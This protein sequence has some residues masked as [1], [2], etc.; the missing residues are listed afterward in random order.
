MFES[1]Q[2]SSRHSLPNMERTFA[3]LSTY[4]QKEKAS[5]F[6]PGRTAR[7]TVPD[8]MAAG[9]HILMTSDFESMDVDEEVA[10]EVEPRGRPALAP[11]TRATA[12]DGESLREVDQVS[13]W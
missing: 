4:M 6:V 12:E 2:T 7:Y 8:A 5:V 1:N 3:V 11:S 10:G 13:A 9:M